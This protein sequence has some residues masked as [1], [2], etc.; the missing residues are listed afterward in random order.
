MNSEKI[1]RIAAGTVAGWSI[2]TMGQPLD[3]LKTLY[4]TRD[5]HLP[6]IKDIYRDIGLLGFYKG[7]SS[8]YLFAGL[9]TALEFETF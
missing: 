2:V 6:A 5:H 3:Y 9:V 4:Q 8:L 1:T 7:A